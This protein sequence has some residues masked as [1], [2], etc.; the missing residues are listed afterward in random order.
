[1]KQ[2]ISTGDIVEHRGKIGKAST[3]DYLYN[4]Y[5]RKMRAVKV[6]VYFF[7]EDEYRKV[8]YEEVRKVPSLERNVRKVLAKNNESDSEK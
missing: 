2:R 1:M 6:K 7:K 5:G 8:P 3:F 4:N